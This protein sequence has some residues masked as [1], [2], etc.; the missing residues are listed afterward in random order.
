LLAL[1]RAQKQRDV[2]M[3]GVTDPLGQP[4]FRDHD[5]SDETDS[6]L[7]GALAHDLRAP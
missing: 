2:V 6:N 5:Q 7:T 3:G 4:R 1:V